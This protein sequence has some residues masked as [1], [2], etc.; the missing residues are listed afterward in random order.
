MIFLFEPRLIMGFHAPKKGS[1]VK[2]KKLSARGNPNYDHGGI[3]V[4][5][6][7]LN[8]K[9]H[10][11]EK[12]NELFISIRNCFLGKNTTPLARRILLEMIEGNFEG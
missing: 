2:S 3:G 6:L 11:Y 12:M 1:Q 10:S 8:F 5:K 9:K 4:L 7:K